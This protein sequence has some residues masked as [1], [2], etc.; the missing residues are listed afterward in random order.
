MMSHA[1]FPLGRWVTAMSRTARSFCEDLAAYVAYV[2][3]T[4][5]TKSPIILISVF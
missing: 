4:C 5:K 2:L 3:G 1:L